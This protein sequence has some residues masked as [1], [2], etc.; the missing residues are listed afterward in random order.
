MSEEWLFEKARDD[1]HT[2]CDDTKGNLCKPPKAVLIGGE[3]LGLRGGVGVAYLTELDAVYQSHDG[4]DA[5]EKS[6]GKDRKDSSLL[7]R[8]HLKL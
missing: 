1:R 4:A 8:R 2:T 5:G 3:L 6:N 7:L